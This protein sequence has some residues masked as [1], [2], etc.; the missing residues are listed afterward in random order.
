[1]AIE[2]I[3]SQL[4]LKINDVDSA[5]ALAAIQTI[6]SAIVN[7]GTNEVNLTMLLNAVKTKL[8][9]PL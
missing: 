9:E 3:K 1:M 7:Q 2:D 6:L 5:K 8:G 4:L